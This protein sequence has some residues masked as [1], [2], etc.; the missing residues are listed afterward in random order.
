MRNKLLNCYKIYLKESKKKNLK[1]Q[2]AGILR[3]LKK[4]RNIKHKNKCHYAI[5]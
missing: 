4:L 1:T 3:F 2:L 5:D